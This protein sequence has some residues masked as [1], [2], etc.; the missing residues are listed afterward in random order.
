MQSEPTTV[1][2]SR[3]TEVELGAL[4]P[5]LRETALEAAHDA[6]FGGLTMDEMTASWEYI[7]GAACAY[8][9]D[10][11]DETGTVRHP[12]AAYALYVGPAGGPGRLGIA[13]GAAATWS[14][15]DDDE[16]GIDAGIQDWLNDAEAWEGRN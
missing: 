16:S 13:W 7:E 3:I 15:V 11:Y 9:I 8:R 14:D 1:R 10:I 6:G 5:D 12:E 4:P 2:T